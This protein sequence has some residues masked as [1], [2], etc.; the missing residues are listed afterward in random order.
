MAE[1]FVDSRVSNPL[2]QKFKFAWYKAESATGVTEA[3]LST[4]AP[5][6]TA[7]PAVSGTVASDDEEIRE[8]PRDLDVADDDDDIWRS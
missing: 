8:E 1:V 6:I 7:M 4:A 5:D 3:P 2:L